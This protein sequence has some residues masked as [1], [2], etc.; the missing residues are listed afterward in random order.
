MKLFLVVLAFA[1]IFITRSCISE[2]KTCNSS[3]D[4]NNPF[5]SQISRSHLRDEFARLHV[6]DTIADLCLDDQVRG[7]VTARRFGLFYPLRE[8]AIY[9]EVAAVAANDNDVLSVSAEQWRD[10]QAVFIERFIHSAL[11]S[12]PFICLEQRH[13]QNASRIW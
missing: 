6:D 10:Q 1:K 9:S 2:L 12:P 8:R 13:F 11:R 3:F 4:V 7:L 5:T